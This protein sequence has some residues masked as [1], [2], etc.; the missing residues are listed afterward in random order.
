MSKPDKISIQTKKGACYYKRGV[1][2]GTGWKLWSKK[3]LLL[4]GA[5]D[6]DRK[7]KKT[8]KTDKD[9]EGKQRQRRQAK[10]EKAKKQT[11][12]F[13]NVRILQRQAGSYRTENQLGIHQVGTLDCY[14]TCQRS[15]LLNGVFVSQNGFPVRVVYFFR[16]NISLFEPYHGKTVEQLDTTCWL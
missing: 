5:A 10:T 11:G 12:I 13:K 14:S 9:R 1:L 7:G 3:N 15:A 16:I 2:Q 4:V 8:E 6:K